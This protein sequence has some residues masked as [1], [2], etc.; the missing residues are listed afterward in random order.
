MRFWMFLKRRVY[1]RIDWQGIEFLFQRPEHSRV[2]FDEILDVFKEK[3][4]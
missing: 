3:S 4:I 1:R 2:A